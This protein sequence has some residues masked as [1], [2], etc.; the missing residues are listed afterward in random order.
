[1]CSPPGHVNKYKKMSFSILFTSL[2]QL[3]EPKDSQ[4]KLKIE[5]KNALFRDIRERET[6]N[7]DNKKLL[8]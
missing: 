7:N 2:T 5:R 3:S 4:R 6:L 8:Q 1:M